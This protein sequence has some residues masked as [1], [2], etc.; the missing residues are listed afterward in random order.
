MENLY[1]ILTDINNIILM[2]FGAVFGLQFI[3]M[4]LFFLPAKKYPKSDVK[5]KFGIIIP[6][7][8]EEIIIANV[9]NTLKGQ[10]YPKD[11]F[12]IFVIADNCTDN[13]AKVARELGA[14]VIER[15]EPDKRF[16]KVGYA[17]KYAF[18]KILA[19]YDN[20]DAFIRFDAD[21]IVHPDYIDK[22]N[23]AFCAG[24]K[25]AR[26]FN[27]TSNFD[28]GLVSAISGLWY[29]RDAR[30]T[31]MPKSALGITQVL[32]GPGMMFSADI[33]RRDG[34]W[35][36]VGTSE[37]ID[38]AISNLLKGTKTYF[39]KD[40]IVYDEQ[41]STLR[42]VFKRNMRMGKGLFKTFWTKATRCLGKFFITFKFSYL[43]M[44]LTQAFIPI[45]L[46]ACVWFPAY[47]IYAI[48][49]NVGIKDM[50]QLQSIG[51]IIGIAL[52]AC[53]VIPFILQA[54][55]VAVLERKNIIAKKRNLILPIL[56]FPMFMIFYALGIFL[57]IILNPRWK[58]IARND[59]ESYGVFIDKMNK[60]AGLISAS[61]D[62]ERV[63][64][65]T[66]G[67]QSTEGYNDDT[68][69]GR[70]TQP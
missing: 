2:V 14:F 52:G 17:L 51:K 57:G 61:E 56:V 62:L 41:P 9:I 15:H 53:F 48:V 13:T 64:A 69:K 8:N 66:D 23:D 21:S 28:Q 45:D 24:V 67:N 60:K 6:A 22:M 37:D 44:F 58:S 32:V 31:C 7:R 39:V 30:F 35:K 65:E 29:L 43:D 42:D 16:H 19:E 20:Y 5:K 12:D 70:E 50:A 10:R 1:N 38:F 4:F 49:Y 34:G 63:S 26:G 27:N 25:I 11:K 59:S 68:L 47:Y 46:V 36:E 40:A 18:E 55:L 3:Y 54:L 33:I